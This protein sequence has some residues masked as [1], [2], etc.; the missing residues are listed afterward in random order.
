MA[1]LLLREG[2][3]HWGL[4]YRF[5]SESR[6]AAGRPFLPITSALPNPPDISFSYAPAGSGARGLASSGFTAVALGRGCRVGIDIEPLAT[7]FP[8]PLSPVFAKIFTPAELAHPL[9]DPVRLWTRKEALLKADGRGLVMDLSQL[10]VLA[11]AVFFDGTAWWLHTV[12]AGP[13]HACSV[14]V[15]A[16]VDA[17]SVR[18]EVRSSV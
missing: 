8:P 18:V 1:R 16:A 10:D 9:A 13:E 7:L 17:A 2:L 15:D 5:A 3:R 6:D 14:A 11:D 12:D 4:P